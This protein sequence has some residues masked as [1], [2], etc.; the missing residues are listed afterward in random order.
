LGRTQNAGK[1]E[2]E[3][4]Q[5]NQKPADRI[6]KRYIHW[7]KKLRELKKAIQESI[8]SLKKKGKKKKG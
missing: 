5:G 7:G 2:K 1:A 8:G 4:H 6:S 3:G